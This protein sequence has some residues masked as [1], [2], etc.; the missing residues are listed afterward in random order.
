MN[1]PPDTMASAARAVGVDE[2][3]A[4]LKRH[5]GVAAEVTLLSA[6]RDQ[7]FCAVGDDGTAYLLKLTHPSEARDFVALQTGAYRHIARV[8]PALPV[9][10]LF[11]TLGG[12]LELDYQRGDEAPTVTRLFS[13][14]PGEPLHRMGR[15]SA[16]RRQLGETLARLGLAL[17]SYSTPFM[18]EPLLWDLQHG[19]Q[20]QP[21]LA[22]IDEATGRALAERFF[23]TISRRTLPRL[24]V[25]R[26]QLI[27]NDFQPWN[28]LVDPQRL[29]HITGVIDFGD[30]VEAPLI[31]DLGV[32]C[33]YHLEEPTHALDG[34]CELLAGY[35]AVSPL[36][37]QEVDLLPD[38][39]ALRLVMTVA[40][41]AWRAKL[42]P[43]NAAYILRNVPLS[44]RGLARLDKLTHSEILER[45]HAACRP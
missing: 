20:L 39:I 10:R 30:M 27:H 32:A 12:E 17:K 3:A 14:M 16:Q 38:L 42:H 4:L 15:N 11:A 35:C 33:A 45:L 6:E 7:N 36:D 34:V 24:A 8:D 31:C 43:G 29:D 40:I 23:D 25:L 9:P 21:L 1:A 19:Q 28:V 41:T 13:F 22:H 44:W 18:F 2:A 37:P 26:R 5:Y